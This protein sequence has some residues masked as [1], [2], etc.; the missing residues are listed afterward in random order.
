MNMPDP[1]TKSHQVL[2]PV[3]RAFRH[4][5]AERAQAHVRAGGHAVLW[6]RSTDRAGRVRKTVH[7]ITPAPDDTNPSDLHRFAVLDLGLPATAPSSDGVFA[8]FAVTRVPASAHWVLDRRVERDS[9]VEGHLH[10]VELDCLRCGSCCK[11]NLVPLD[12]TDRGRLR[13]AGHAYTLSPPWTRRVD[14]KLALALVGDDE[15]CVQ[16]GAN[17]AC[18]V[19]EARPG[20]CREF[21]AG[22]ECCISVREAEL[23]L[24][25][26]LA[27]EQKPL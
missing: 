11:K 6:A 2:R 18:G 19:Y 23:S 21:P 12:A 24:Y 5:F 14:G 20:P 25:D 10:A 16:L 22:S 3:V 7:L 15:R 9:I 26:G 8:G 13:R 4:D 17:N 1:A 27:P